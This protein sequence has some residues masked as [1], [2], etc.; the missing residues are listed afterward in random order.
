[1]I[2]LTETIKKLEVVVWGTLGSLGSSINR[3]W[4]KAERNIW[5]I[6]YVPEYILGVV[7]GIILSDGYIQ[8]TKNGINARLQFGQSIIHFEYFWFVF[9]LLSPLCISLPYLS[10]QVYKGVTFFTLRLSTR[11]LPFLTDLYTLFYVNGVKV[12]PAEEIMYNLLTP[13]ALAHWI[14][15]DGTW[16]GRGVQLCTDSFSIQDV[17]RLISILRIRYDLDCTLQMCNRGNNKNYPRI[18]IKAESIP[19]LRTL[20]IP[21]I[22]SSMFYKLGL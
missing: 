6:G 22:H 4:T 21:Y 16:I 11:A 12:I 7:V 10:S 19:L 1:M 2:K 3:R 9:Q 18:Y 13:I 5:S 14:Q 8:I 17:V 15:C 20:V